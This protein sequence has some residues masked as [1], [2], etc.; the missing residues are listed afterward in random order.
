MTRLSYRI[1]DVCRE[2]G[3]SRN[4]VNRRIDAGQIRTRRSGGALLLCPEDVE[5]VYGWVTPQTEPKREDFETA[6]A[7]LS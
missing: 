7:L 3:V 2:A 4:H 6:E 5:R 1:A